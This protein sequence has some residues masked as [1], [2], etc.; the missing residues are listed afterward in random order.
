LLRLEELNSPA[1]RAGGKE[2]QL[3]KAKGLVRLQVEDKAG[4]GRGELFDLQQ[5]HSPWKGLALG[6]ASKKG[7]G[8][9]QNHPRRVLQHKQKRPHLSLGVDLQPSPLRVVVPA[10]NARQTGN[11]SQLGLNG[12][13][14]K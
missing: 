2:L 13:G 10:V 7:V 12:Q 1:G 3:V 4:D 9:I 11:G 14:G 6:L 8:K 5:G